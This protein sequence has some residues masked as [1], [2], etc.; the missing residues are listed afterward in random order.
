MRATVNTFAMVVASAMVVALMPASAAADWVDDKCNG[1]SYEISIWKKSQA[2]SYAQIGLGEG[3]HW[4]GGCWNDNNSDDTP[5][6]EE[7]EAFP[8]GEGPDCSGFTFKSWALRNDYGKNGKRQWDRKK[9]MH[10]PYAAR[11]FKNPPGSP[12]ANVKKKNAYTMEAFASSTHIGMI[13]TPKTSQGQ[14]RIIEAKCDDC[15]VVRRLRNY[16]SQSAYEGAKRTGW[17]PE[18]YPQCV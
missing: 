18:C 9:F 15:G 3:Y 14:D 6:M 12:I 1:E 13:W 16:R 7:Q 4:G 8:R 10:G 11:D 17:T 2:Q 5:N